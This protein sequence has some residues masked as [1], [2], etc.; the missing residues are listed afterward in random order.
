VHSR[1]CLRQLLQV[2]QWS[3]LLCHHIRIY[4]LCLAVHCTSELERLGLHTPREVRGCEHGAVEEQRMLWGPQVAE[5][6]LCVD[7]ERA[8]DEPDVS[9]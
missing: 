8:W 5:V 3:H 4:G 2:Y 6:G 9:E 1:D 7:A